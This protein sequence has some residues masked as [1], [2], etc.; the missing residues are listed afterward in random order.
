[1]GARVTP[2]VPGCTKGERTNHSSRKSKVGIAQCTYLLRDKRKTCL[3]RKTVLQLCM[4][5]GM[6]RIVADLLS[7][8]QKQYATLRGDEHEVWLSKE[9]GSKSVNKRMHCRS[10][11][12]PQT[13]IVAISGGRTH[14]VWAPEATSKTPFRWEPRKTRAL[15]ST[16]CGPGTTSYSVR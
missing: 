12:S 14:V 8:R 3:Q 13:F 5:A 2:D 11:V 4:Q 10:V 1:M 6:Q 7:S 9:G 16:C 15:S